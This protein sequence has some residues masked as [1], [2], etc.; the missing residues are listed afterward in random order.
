MHARC[1]AGPSLAR[2]DT[3]ATEWEALFKKPGL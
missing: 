1:V 3:R 2:W